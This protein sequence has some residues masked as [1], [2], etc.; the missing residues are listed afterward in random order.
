ME[1]KLLE[2]RDRMT[3]IPMLAI[4]PVP[5]SEEERYLLARA[6][7]GRAPESQVCY[8][9]L[10]RL[11]GG[12]LHWDPYSWG[13]NGDRTF[14]TVHHWLLEHWAEVESGDVVDAEFIR[15]ETTEPKVSERTEA[16]T[17]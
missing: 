4:K 1:V 5:R 9:L 17:W 7:Y 6:G 3:F 16:G 10:C 14:G 8:V 2:V 15:G 12:Q 13:Q 11:D